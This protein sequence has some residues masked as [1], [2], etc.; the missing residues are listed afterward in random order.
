MTT[1]ATT[2]A[3]IERLDLGVS[4]EDLLDGDEDQAAGT[5]RHRLGHRGSGITETAARLANTFAEVFIERRKGSSR[6]S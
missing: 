3:V 5:E 2:D 4:R 6:A 1:P